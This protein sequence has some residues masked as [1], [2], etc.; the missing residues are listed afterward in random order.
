MRSADA[1]P[2][3]SLMMERQAGTRKKNSGL[4]VCKYNESSRLEGRLQSRGEE[5]RKEWSRE[6]RRERRRRGRGGGEGIIGPNG[7]A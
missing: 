3:R 7:S 5:K 6:R 1:S 4:K 2:A